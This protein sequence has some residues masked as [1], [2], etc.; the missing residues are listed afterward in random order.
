[1]S[2]NLKFK[3]LFFQNKECHPAE[4]KQAYG[5]LY[6]L[7]C[8]EDK[9]PKLCLVMNF[10]IH[11]SQDQVYSPRNSDS[12]SITFHT[13]LLQ[14]GW[15]SG[16]L[17]TFELIFLEHSYEACCIFLLSCCCHYPVKN[18]LKLWSFYRI[19]IPAKIPPAQLSLPVAVFVTAVYFILNR[20]MHF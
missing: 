9:N 2:K 13:V 20:S 3:L 14:R 7:L 12:T 8:D 5:N 4:N 18:H 11:F 15:L 17:D 10:M 16:Y 6:F 19:T 1:M